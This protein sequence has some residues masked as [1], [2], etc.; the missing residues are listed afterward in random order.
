MSQKN[1]K[2]ESNVNLWQFVLL[3]V[4]LA[5]L[6][7]VAL[8]M[9]LFTRTTISHSIHM[10]VSASAGGYAIITYQ[11]GKSDSGGTITV[12]TPWRKNFTVPGGSQIYLTA[13]NPAQTGSISCL[14]EVDGQ[15]W[16]YEKV[17]Y[18]KEAVACAGITPNR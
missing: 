15:E 13:G 1:T 7:F 11:A 17:T 18:P 9:G 10:E 6:V 2:P 8:Q 14:I 4:I 5:G 16:K 3:L 12:T